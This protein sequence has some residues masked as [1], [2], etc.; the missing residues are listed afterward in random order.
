[1]AL[2]VV[3]IN[4]SG[5][6][7]TAASGAGPA[8]ALFGTAAAT[9]ASTV[10]TLLVDNPDLSGVATD[11]SAAIWI[12]S[13]SGRRW[14]RITAVNNTA[15]VKTVTVATAFANTESG[16]NWGIGGKRATLAG[17]AQLFKDFESGWVID[18][19]S[20]ET[21]TAD[22]VVTPA[23]TNT[24]SGP[25][26]IASSTFTGVWGTQPLI[27]TA[28]S[29]VCGFDVSSVATTTGLNI[30]GLSFKCT[31]GTP[32]EGNSG[33]VPKGGHTN[34]IS[35]AACIFDGWY[36][37]LDGV[38]GSFNRFKNCTVEQCEIK[39]CTHDG[40]NFAP[41]PLVL[42]KCYIHDN[43]TS[44][45]GNGAIGGGAGGTLPV[46]IIEDTIVSG[47]PNAGISIGTTSNSLII[48]K[49]SAFFNNGTAGSGSGS[50]CGLNDSTTS[51]LYVFEDNIFW[52][53]GQS[54][55]SATSSGANIA[56]LNPVGSVFR[57][58]AF[59]G[60]NQTV[61]YQNGNPVNEQNQIA[62]T[63]DPRTSSTDYLLN[64]TAGGGN[65]CRNASD[66]CA[67]ASAT[68]TNPDIGAVP[69]GGGGAAA[70]GLLVYNNADSLGGGH[71]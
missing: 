48:V 27:Q 17:S 41:D 3:K 12:G 55:Q 42:I 19:Q 11:G 37:G 16:K 65:S 51:P 34:C 38:N 18:P 60:T 26:T 40:I 46:H 69:S 35:I 29:G 23:T 67:N 6:S 14:S 71:A 15:G 36:Y 1:M 21:F 5:S 10:V 52:A 8:T 50:R 63:V 32:V 59:G 58:N 47:H 2:P 20:G 66:L 54:G 24:G 7:D 30:Y 4:S 49:G 56:S 9:A 33:L 28:T 70:G 61:S 53:N 39:N 68:A 31:V 44:G 25:P 13:S 64:K 57:N 62:L 43:A 45:T 22:I